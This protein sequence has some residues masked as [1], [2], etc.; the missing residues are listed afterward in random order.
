[1]SLLFLCVSV[2]KAQIVINEEIAIVF[3]EQKTTI[4]NQSKLSGNLHIV[5][6]KKSTKIKIPKRINLRNTEFQQNIAIKRVNKIH[7]ETYNPFFPFD[8]LAFFSKY[9]LQ[10]IALQEN[11]HNCKLFAQNIFKCI[12]SENIFIIKHFAIN[13]YIVSSNDDYA[14]ATGNL[15]PPEIC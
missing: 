10:N 1:M 5:H 12:S 6:Q 7:K 2:A 11:F 15:P 4:V 13:T 8:N 3:V 9:L 14:C